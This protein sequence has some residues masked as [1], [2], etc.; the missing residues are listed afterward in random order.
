LF[1]GTTKGDFFDLA[2]WID[3]GLGL[4]EDFLGL[5]R[6]INALLFFLKFLD[7]FFF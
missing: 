2:N 3:L 7:F 5:Q 6:G 1:F 4:L